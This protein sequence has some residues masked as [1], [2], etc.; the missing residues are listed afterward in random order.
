MTPQPRG[1]GRRREANHAPVRP[2]A[3]AV[4]QDSPSTGPHEGCRSG[5]GDAGREVGSATGTATETTRRA[6]SRAL[7]S[8]SRTLGPHRDSRAVA[9]RLPIW[10]REVW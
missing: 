2:T 8:I 9:A 5:E 6:S 3:G 1:I 4:G 7:R 10:P